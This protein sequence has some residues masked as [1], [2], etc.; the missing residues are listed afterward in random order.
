[1]R[2]FKKIV[3]V[4]IASINAKKNYKKSVEINPRKLA[5][6]VKSSLKLCEVSSVPVHHAN[7]RI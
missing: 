3:V 2:K 7:V 4:F 1:M 6:Y 5:L